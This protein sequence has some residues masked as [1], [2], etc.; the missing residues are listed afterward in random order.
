MD[1]L[2]PREFGPA[3]SCR[4]NS[5]IDFDLSWL[6]SWRVPRIQYIVDGKDPET[7]E[8]GT[9]AMKKLPPPLNY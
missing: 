6:L 9:F 7:A 3:R 4:T 2:P 5:G 8:C 1:P